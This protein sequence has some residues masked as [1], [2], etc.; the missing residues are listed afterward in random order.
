[1]SVQFLHKYV[2]LHVTHACFQATTFG[3]SLCLHSLLHVIETWHERQV[4]ISQEYEACVGVLF[5][6]AVRTM[7][8]RNHI[9]I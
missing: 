1:M 9:M 3:F 4:E 7:W 5:Q 6:T 8:S 2:C